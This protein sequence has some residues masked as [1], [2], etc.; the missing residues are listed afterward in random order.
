M[1]TTQRCPYLSITIEGVPQKVSGGCVRL[2]D[3]PSDWEGRFRWHVDFDTPE[4]FQA[5]I[6]KH[7]KGELQ[8]DGA[9]GAQPAPRALSTLAT[10]GGF[11][12][13]NQSP[14]GQ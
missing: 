4:K 1:P 2:K 11:K 5:H 14:T 12:T 8:P 3:T 10:T 7:L 6:M 9:T 13:P